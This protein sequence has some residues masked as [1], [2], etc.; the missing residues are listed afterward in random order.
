MDIDL[1]RLHLLDKGPDYHRII[2]DKDYWWNV[3][4][5]D[6]RIYGKN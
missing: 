4:G 2:I 6:H 5:K 1:R 3:P